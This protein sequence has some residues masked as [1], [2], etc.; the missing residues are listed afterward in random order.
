MSADA[1]G[2]AI[3][4]QSGRVRAPVPR[5]HWC[6]RTS[7]ASGGN[8]TWSRCEPACNSDQVRGE[9]GVQN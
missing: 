2:K 5:R 6:R 8:T 3:E 7:R 1:A 4:A 9:T